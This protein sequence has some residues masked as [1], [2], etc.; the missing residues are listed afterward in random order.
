MLRYRVRRGDHNL[1]GSR[2]VAGLG[3]HTIGGGGYRAADRGIYI[4][5]IIIYIYYIIYILYYIYIYYIYIL[6]IY[7]YIYMLHGS[8]KSPKR[9]PES[10]SFTKTEGLWSDD[11]RQRGRVGQRSSRTPKLGKLLY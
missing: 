2:G 3:D 9:S 5:I 10:Q 11:L 4:Y 8:S 7:I 1:G 6:F